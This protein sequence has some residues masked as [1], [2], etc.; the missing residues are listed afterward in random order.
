[1]FTPFVRVS[2]TDRAN[3]M[4]SN[5]STVNP[6][7]IIFVEGSPD[8]TVASEIWSNGIKYANYTYYNSSN[9]P[10]PSA[11][12]YT[13]EEI[14]SIV[15]D[16]ITYYIDENKNTVW[17]WK[18]IQPTGGLTETQVRNIVKSMIDADN[19]GT[20]DWEEHT[21]YYMTSDGDGGAWG[22]WK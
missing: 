11:P 1:M 4:N 12:S 7:K 10:I 9:T 16:R 19:S 22:D 2:Y 15:N 20:P 13:R 5:Y 17:D 3:F 18:E 8:G 6:T 14:E 21:T